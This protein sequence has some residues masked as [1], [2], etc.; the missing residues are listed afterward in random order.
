MKYTD[1]AVLEKER[2]KGRNLI[3]AIEGET[4][5]AVGTR[6]ESVKKQMDL[7]D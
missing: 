2:Y 1:A 7:K 6:A 5:V 4:F 3:S